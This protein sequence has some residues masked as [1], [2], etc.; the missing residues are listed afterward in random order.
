[1]YARLVVATTLVGMV[2]ALAAPLVGS[3][4][5][6]AARSYAEWLRDALPADTFGADVH[7]AVGEAVE[8]TLRTQPQSAEAFWTTLFDLLADDADAP[9][10]EAVA[11]VVDTAHGILLE[12][13]HKNVRDHV[14]QALLPRSLLIATAPPAQTNLSQRTFAKLA[15]LPQPWSRHLIEGIQSSLLVA[16]QPILSVRLLSAAQPLG[17]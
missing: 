17:P 13:W 8:A 7:H 5:H 11:D 4:Q 2:C 10:A 14:G 12:Q 15:A 1:M 16:E 9:S 3:A 6:I